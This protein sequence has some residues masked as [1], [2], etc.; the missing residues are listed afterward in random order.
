M[1]ITVTWRRSASC[2]WFGSG[3]AARGSAV[4][5]VP[6]VASTLDVDRLRDAA[7]QSATFRTAL[8]RHG[9]DQRILI[10]AGAWSLAPALPRTCLSTFAS[11]R[12]AA[13]SVLS[14]R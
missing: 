10:Q 13:T 6:G 12:R 7:D 2:P 9:L 14:S 5:L 1:N 3:T 11:S 4:V 8:A